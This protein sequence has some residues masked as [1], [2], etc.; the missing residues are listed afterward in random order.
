LI[1]VIYAVNFLHG[2]GEN[3]QSHNY[4]QQPPTSMNSI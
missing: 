2:Q 1:P 3:V 4:N